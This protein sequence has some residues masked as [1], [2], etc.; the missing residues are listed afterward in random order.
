MKQQ[1]AQVSQSLNWNALPELATW[2]V[3]RGI[4]I[5]QVAAPTFEEGNR[6]QFVAELFRELGLSQVS[7][8]ELHNVYGLLPG[9]DTSAPALMLSAH[10]DTIFPADTD[11]TIRRDGQLIFGPGLG[12]NSIGVSGM[13][14][15]AA[16]LRQ[17]GITPARNIWFVAP[18]R[19]E[20]LGDLGGIKAAFARLKS[21]IRYVIN[22][23]GL[24]FGHIYHAG[25]A[26]RRLKINTHAPGGHSWLHYGKAS[27][28]HSLMQ[29][30]NR[31]IMLK[32]P[33]ASRTTL[34]I[35]LIEGGQAINAIARTASLWLDLRS[36]ESTTLGQFEAQVQREIEAT[37]TTDLTI[38]VE[39]VGDRPAGRISANHPLVEA[40][41]AS[42]EQVGVR[43]TLE[44]GSTDANIPLSQGCPAVTVGITRGG[45]AH[46]LDEYIETPPVASGLRHLLTLVLAAD[47][48]E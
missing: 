32:P 16:W 46:R 8:D 21:E 41:L 23:E 5:Q 29:L 19:E 33:T 30:G 24:A 25:I 17:H 44:N 27:A 18:V 40:A 36:E 1:V 15:V 45:N 43:G 26:V 12:D 47:S 6:A 37:K 22:I 34:N 42:L 9:Q 20:G 13:L 7:V 38:D 4:A 35:G 11:L 2:V 14:A 28:V 10:T 31:L 39:V 3:E 48:F